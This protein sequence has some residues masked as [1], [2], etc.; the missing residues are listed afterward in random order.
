MIY[1]QI[2][3]TVV[4]IVIEYD[5]KLRVSVIESCERRGGLITILLSDSRQHVYEDA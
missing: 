2:I 5:H 1:R 3:Y 4:S